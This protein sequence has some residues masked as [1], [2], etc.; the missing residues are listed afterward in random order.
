MPPLIS[1]EKVITNQV[2][3]CLLWIETILPS[4]LIFYSILNHGKRKGTGK[5]IQNII[6]Q[7]TE[8]ISYLI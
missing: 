1:E 3:T 8:F 7:R 2:G 5:S 6:L 4:Y